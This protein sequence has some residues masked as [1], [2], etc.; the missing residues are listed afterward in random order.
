MFIIVLFLLP[1]PLLFQ[2]Y[3]IIKNIQ[4]GYIQ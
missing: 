3:E 4:K 1:L 2:Q